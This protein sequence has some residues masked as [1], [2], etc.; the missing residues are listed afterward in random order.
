VQHTSRREFELALH[1]AAPEPVDIDRTI[2]AALG[3]SRTPPTDQAHGSTFIHPPSAM[4]RFSLSASARSAR[5]RHERLGR[6]QLPSRCDSRR[7]RRRRLH[8]SSRASRL[9]LL[10]F[11]DASDAEP[12]H[13]MRLEASGHGAIIRH[14][15][16]DC[17]S[18]RSGRRDV[19]RDARWARPRPPARSRPPARWSYPHRP[20]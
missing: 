3:F 14:H 8:L 19:T 13:V 11:D 17:D 2:R 9:E 10:L 18:A 1:R 16:R 15:I 12:A 5:R 7:G 6:S 20:R 4:G